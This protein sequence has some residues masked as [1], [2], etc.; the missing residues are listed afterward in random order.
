MTTIKT[1]L[2]I[3]FFFTDKTET[4]R[5]LIMN[6]T[7]PNGRTIARDITEWRAVGGSKEVFEAN[8]HLIDD[9]DGDEWLDAYTGDLARR[10]AG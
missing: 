10:M 6:I 7:L 2:P 8:L 1:T 5:V 9:P 4:G 3:R